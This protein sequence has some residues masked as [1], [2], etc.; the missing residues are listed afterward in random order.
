MVLLY[1]LGILLEPVLLV[2]LLM[3]IMLVQ[4]MQIMVLLVLVL[5]TP[6]RIMIM[7]EMRFFCCE[8]C[9]FNYLF[10]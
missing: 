1:L 4:L 8:C 5:W 6:V 3:E 9:F 2:Q 7:P 10:K